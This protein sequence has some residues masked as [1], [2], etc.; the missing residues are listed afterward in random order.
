MFDVFCLSDS[1][2]IVWLKYYYLKEMLFDGLKSIIYNQ[3]YQFYQWNS[4]RFK[5]SADY[6]YSLNIL[7]MLKLL[8]KLYNLTRKQ[9]SK[10][11]IKSPVDI[12]RSTFQLIHRSTF[13]HR[14]YLIDMK[15]SFYYFE[16]H[17]Y[18]QFFIMLRS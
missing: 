13:I 17:I 4:M 8:N 10:C 12:H 1:H 3:F 2:S 7:T 9:H 11:T 18:H 5:F 15:S 16:C 14:N 6:H